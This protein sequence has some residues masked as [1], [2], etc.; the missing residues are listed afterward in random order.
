MKNYNGWTGPMD[1]HHKNPPAPFNPEHRP[2]AKNIWGTIAPSMEADGFYDNHTREECSIEF[3]RRYKLA[4]AEYE[5][6]TGYVHGE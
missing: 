2:H 5:D 6:A 3:K 1:F 4:M